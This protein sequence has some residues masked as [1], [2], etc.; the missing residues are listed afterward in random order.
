MTFPLPPGDCNAR[1]HVF[2]PGAR[3]PYAPDA[4]FLPKEDSPKEALYALNDGLGLERCV[5][6]QSACHGFDNRATEDAVASRSRATAGSR[7]C[8]PMSRARN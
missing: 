6:V 1:C 7:C 3:F 4:S 8:R 5:V 2:G